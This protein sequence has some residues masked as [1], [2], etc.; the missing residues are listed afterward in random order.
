MNVFYI[1]LLCPQT[2]YSA[3]WQDERLNL[4]SESACPTECQ[5][6]VELSLGV[7]WGL[8]ISFPFIAVYWQLNQSWF[9]SSWGKNLY[10]PAAVLPKWQGM[11]QWCFNLPLQWSDG[12][13]QGS[14]LCPF[15]MK[16]FLFISRQSA[17]HDTPFIY[18][19]NANVVVLT[20]LQIVLVAMFFFC[21]FFV[22]LVLP[23]ILGTE[24]ISVFLKRVRQTKS[25]VFPLNVVRFPLLTSI[26]L[27]TSCALPS[28]RSLVITF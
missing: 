18:S 27:C 19:D 15:S 8:T 20:S 10:C 22:S 26:F 16:V 11:M 3:P 14:D 2:F 25:A 7:R 6:K 5:P 17:S 23:W 28:N 12:R 21:Q 1:I 4:N 13:A 24:V 9:L